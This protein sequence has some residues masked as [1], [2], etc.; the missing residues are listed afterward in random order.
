MFFSF[1][2]SKANRFSNL[3]AFVDNLPVFASEI[4]KRN[5]LQNDDPIFIEIVH[6]LIESHGSTDAEI[7]VAKKI[8]GFDLHYFINYRTLESELIM[9]DQYGELIT[10]RLN[11][12]SYSDM[13]G[14]MGLSKLT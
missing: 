12:V 8:S 6:H 9:S 1:F 11:L 4:R 10:D 3:T 13:N 5:G 7:A 14:D 2:A